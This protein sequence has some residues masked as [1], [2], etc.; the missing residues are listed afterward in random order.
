[1]AR[2]HYFGKLKRRVV[3]AL[4]SDT[5]SSINSSLCAGQDVWLIGKDNEPAGQV[6]TAVPYG[7]QLALMV[8]LPLDMLESPAAQFE[9]RLP[10]QTLQLKVLGAPYDL[11]QKGNVFEAI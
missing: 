1:M 10:A 9:L 5:H 4:T 8:E 7:Q 2:S 11:H 6:I 3:N